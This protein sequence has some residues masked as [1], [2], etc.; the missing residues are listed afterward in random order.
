M[1]Y[2]RRDVTRGKKRREICE[3]GL[4]KRG[5]ENERRS[6]RKRDIEKRVRVRGKRET[7]QEKSERGR[8]EER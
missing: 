6:E 3:R 4:E 2:L 5:A 8:E 7:L 1:E